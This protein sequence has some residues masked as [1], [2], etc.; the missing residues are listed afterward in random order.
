MSYEAQSV[1][2]GGVNLLYLE[3]EHFTLE[4]FRLYVVKVV[5]FQ[6][7][8]GGQWWYVVMC[9][10]APDD[11]STIEVAVMAISQ[12]PCGADLL[13]VGDFNDDLVVL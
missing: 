5:S 10:L 9:Y 3:A 2:I 7:S 13:M 6:L 1:H 11:A 4:A 8:L 12:R